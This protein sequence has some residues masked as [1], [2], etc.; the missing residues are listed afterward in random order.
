MATNIIMHKKKG[1]SS[2]VINE[3]FVRLLKYRI[4]IVSKD[5]NKVK[6]FCLTEEPEGLLDSITPI[7]YEGEYPTEDWQFL[8]LFKSPP[9][10]S[11]ASFEKNVL[12]SPKLIPLDLCQSAIL[13]NIP[14]KGHVNELP[15]G[16]GMDITT[17]ET[18][19]NK[20]LPFVEM[21]MAWWNDEGET[22]YKGEWFF[23]WIGKDISDLADK[24]TAGF[25]NPWK[26]VEDNFK[27][28]V[29]PTKL[30][31][32]SPY[33]L[34]NQ[35]KNEDLVQQY[36]EKIRPYFPQEWYPPMEEEMEAALFSYGHEWRD[37]TPQVRFIYLEGDDDPK[38]DMYAR[39]W[40]L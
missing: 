38:T 21:P 33:Y 1:V 16:H 14:L 34:N 30:A 22:Q 27:G 32:F 31:Q 17:M 19:Q 26:F 24:D 7:P 12:L 15:A 18:V 3:S 10:Q 20:E 37:V 4:D 36:E 28:V 9:Y 11:E 13:G 5:F 40:F 2:E 35:E 23:G 39:L 6:F 25:D 8:Q 29:L